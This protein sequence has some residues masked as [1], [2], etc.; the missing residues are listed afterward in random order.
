MLKGSDEHAQAEVC[1]FTV[2]PRQR[3][4]SAI[5]KSLFDARLAAPT[6]AQVPELQDAL[7]SLGDDLVFEV[8]ETFEDPCA[9][10]L[11]K[12][13]NQIE[14][15]FQALLSSRQ[16]ELRHWV[17]ENIYSKPIYDARAYYD[18]GLAA[19]ILHEYESERLAVGMQPLSVQ[20]RTATLN[21]I[22]RMV[23]DLTEEFAKS[24]FT[25]PNIPASSHPDV[26]RY[27]R[28]LATF[29]RFRDSEFLKS[30]TAKEAYI[31]LF[32]NIKQIRNSIQNAALRQRNWAI[33]GAILVVGVFT[34][35]LLKR[36]RQ[37]VV[38]RRSVPFTPEQEDYADRQWA[39]TDY[40]A[41][42]P[43][44]AIPYEEFT[45]EP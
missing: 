11:T 43:P 1:L 20:D 23:L 45:D 7:G 40:P 22:T 9:E 15:I 2:Y 28:N 4:E 3:V 38:Q 31:Q 21:Y 25:P 14:S 33:G 39:R 30:S 35:L 24:Q 6:L 36:P 18:S 12:D 29:P 16:D 5:L 34:T 41:I 27:L 19:A 8:L 10:I 32:S 37:K 42:I 17:V 26:L 13:S 44:A